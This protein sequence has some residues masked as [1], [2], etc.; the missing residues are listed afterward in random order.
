M[1]RTELIQEM[2]H[3]QLSHVPA[4]KKLM[5]KDLWRITKHINN[6]IFDD[7]CCVWDGYVTNKYVPNKGSYVNFYFQR[8]KQALHR[9]L[10]ANFVGPIGNTDMIRFTCNRRGEC[11]NVMHMK[12]QRC[13]VTVASHTNKQ[14]VPLRKRVVDNNLTVVFE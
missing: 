2:T 6:S 3:K 12:K 14:R 13:N 7:G 9:L 1:T 8:K 10:Y 11:C 5:Y 4:D